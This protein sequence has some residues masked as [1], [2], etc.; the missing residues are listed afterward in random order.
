MTTIPET[1]RVAFTENAQGFTDKATLTAS[2]RDG[3]DEIVWAVWDVP[4][5]DDDRE[6]ATLI[7]GL[8]LLMY[9]YFTDDG[10]FVS[11]HPAEMMDEYDMVELEQEILSISG[12]LVPNIDSNVP[13]SEAYEMFSEVLGIPASLLLATNESLPAV[14]VSAP[15]PDSEM[16]L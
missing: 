12:E 16:T 4:Q 13:A 11:V 3:S 2:K 7:F 10:D 6:A 9:G 1:V 15:I 8:A 14:V 5:T